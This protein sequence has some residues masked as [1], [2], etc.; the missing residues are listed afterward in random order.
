MSNRIKSLN[1]YTRV[2]IITYTYC[3]KFPRTASNHKPSPL[4]SKQQQQIRRLV[5]AFYKKIST[6]K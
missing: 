6:V 3:W 2:H 4:F 1:N 5:A